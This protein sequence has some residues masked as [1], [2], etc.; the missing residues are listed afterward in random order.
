MTRAHYTEQRQGA[1]ANYGPML[2]RHPRR[3]RA[4]CATLPISYRRHRGHAFETIIASR[5]R[6]GTAL[7]RRIAA[8]TI[9]SSS[10][11][12]ATGAA[13]SP[14]YQGSFPQAYG[15]AGGAVRSGVATSS[16][17]VKSK[18]NARTT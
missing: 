5:A 7:P 2:V 4:F 14:A 12:L 17:K 18:A 6:R 11:G 1:V 10:P 15:G 3:E 13:V 9:T 8:A 16:S